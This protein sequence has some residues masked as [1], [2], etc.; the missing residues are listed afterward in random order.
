MSAEMLLFAQ[1]HRTI[2][3][4]HGLQ[5][6]FP[7][8]RSRLAQASESA[9]MPLLPH[10]PPSFC[11]ILAEAVLLT[12]RGHR[13]FWLLKNLSL[14]GASADLRV[15]RD[16][17]IARYAFRPSSN[18]SLKSKNRVLIVSYLNTNPLFPR[19]ISGNAAS[20]STTTLLAYEVVG[21]SKLT[22][23]F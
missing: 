20:G 23:L 4:N 7:T 8:N 13:F 14:R 12:A 21:I 15:G 6:S 5:H 11:L 10:C 16:V 17:A 19:L 2:R 18:P 1:S 9:A 22:I 3:Q